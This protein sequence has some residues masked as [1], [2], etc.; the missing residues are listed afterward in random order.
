VSPYYPYNK[1]SG[2]SDLGGCIRSMLLSLGKAT[3]AAIGQAANAGGAV[4]KKAAKCEIELMR[5]IINPVPDH[6]PWSPW[7]E[8]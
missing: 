8:E 1:F 2:P 4:Y 5:G 3:E 6:F 7:V